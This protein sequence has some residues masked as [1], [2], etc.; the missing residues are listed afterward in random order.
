MKIIETNFKDLL[1][2][3]LDKYIDERGFF[4]ERYSFDKFLQFGLSDK[5]VQDNFSRSKSNV[6]RGLH[7]QYDQPQ[8][9]LVGCTR[10]LIIDVV[11]DIR[12]NSKTFGQHFSIELSDENNRLLWIPAGFAHGF[13]VPDNVAVADVMYKVNSNYNPAGE[14]GILWND[15]KVAINWGKYG[16]KEPVVSPKDQILLSFE[17]YQKNPKFF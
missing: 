13:C 5:F 1:I 14:G 4:T 11:I 7:Y 17:A 3:E 15:E 2:I 6:I 12:V 8:G 9:K 10:G 16:V